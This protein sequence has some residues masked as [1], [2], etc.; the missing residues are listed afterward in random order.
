MCGLVTVIQLPTNRTAS[1][2]AAGQYHAAATHA[3]SSC[4][5]GDPRGE[6]EVVGKRSLAPA[7]GTDTAPV[8]SSIRGYD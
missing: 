7:K 1:S 8:A 4:N 2:G 6:P 3:P 5:E